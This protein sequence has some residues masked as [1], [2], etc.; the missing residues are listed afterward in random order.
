MGIPDHRGGIEL[1]GE[2]SVSAPGYREMKPTEES[3]ER[4]AQR[5]VELVH[6]LRIVLFG[7]YARGESRPDSD[8]DLLGVFPAVPALARKFV[9]A[10]P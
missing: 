6:P 1:P 4:L 10:P 7:S 8:I 9:C 3:N 5:I 2:I